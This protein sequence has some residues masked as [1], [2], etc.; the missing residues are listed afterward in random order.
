L[1][2]ACLNGLRSSAGAEPN[3]GGCQRSAKEQR[4]DDSVG[5][6]LSVLALCDCRSNAV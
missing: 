4:L 2:L 1:D 5:S 6:Q 3:K